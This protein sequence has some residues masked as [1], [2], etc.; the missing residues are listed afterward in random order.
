MIYQLIYSSEAA[1]NL[2]D[3]DLEDL[4]H[5]SRRDNAER[6]V[7]GALMFVDRVF[8]QVLEGSRAAVEALMA[9]IERDPRHHSVTVF[10][11]TEA[12]ERVFDS[13]QMAFINPDSVAISRWAGLPGVGSMEEI[14]AALDQ[15]PDRV[16]AV[17]GKIVRTLS[18]AGLS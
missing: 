13:W 15:H 17:L 10:H 7:T 8:V 12:E 5:D 3:S 18:A 1:A 16:P 4:L 14:V 2:T 9:K 11:E 6:G